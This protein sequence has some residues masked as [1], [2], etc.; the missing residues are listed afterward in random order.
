MITV[1]T[2]LSF[3]TM[4]EA[5]ADAML[6]AEESGHIVLVNPA[7]QQLFGY[8]AD[9]LSGLA[10]EIL[11]V[12][13][14]RKQYRYH[15][16]IFLNK[17]TKRSMGAGNELMVLSRDGKEMLL[18]ISLSP[19]RVQQQL[20]VLITFN[21]INRRLDV[22]EALRISE[23]RLRLA[24][25]AA[26]LGIFDY[27]I[28]R[29]IIYWDKQMRKLWGEPS[30]TT[31]S[32]EEFVARIHPEDRAARQTVIEYAMNPAGNGEFKAEYRIVDPINSSE[33]WISAS[34]RVY[35][36]A[37]Y[38]NR[39][40]GVTRDVTEQKNA[41]KKLQMQRDETENI[42]KQQIAARTASAIAHELNQPLAAISAYSE[43]ALHA[44]HNDGFTS[45]SLKRALEGCVEQAQRAGRSLHELLAFLQ[46]G[47]LVTERLNL[48]DLIRDALTIVSN[49]GHGKFYLALRLQQNLPVVQC[50]RIQ[51]QKVLVNLF[52]NA[53][54]AMRAVDLPTLTITT[55]IDTMNGTDKALVIVQ[56]N[57]PGLDAVMTKR[58]FEPFFTT[59]PAGIG[60]GLAISRALIETNGGHLWLDSDTQSG[61]KFLFTLPFAP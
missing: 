41:Q 27:D 2:N 11:I 3:V 24:K 35:F 53:D 51:V 29:N 58:I 52:R 26:G 18:D 39:L 56:D 15:Q 17:P 40:I 34:G 21:A 50:N 37:G 38:A 1:P 55:Q 48:N 33:R 47:E 12:P 57:G 19:I 59:K 23:E 4:F 6:L 14:Y 7:A 16:E 54:E 8:S 25:Q 28:K 43:V 31:V 22:E 44:I 30:E 36:E 60:M 46:K 42:L 9:E 45:D 20:Y 32:Y 49:D 13:R 10:I 61:A 5:A